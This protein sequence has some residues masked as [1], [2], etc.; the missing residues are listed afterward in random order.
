ML[1]KERLIR[2]RTESRGRKEYTSDLV[3]GNVFPHG[4][5]SNMNSHLVLKHS[6][7]HPN[8]LLQISCSRVQ[9]YADQK[10]IKLE[11]TPQDDQKIKWTYRWRS[12]WLMGRNFSWAPVK[13][14]RSRVWIQHLHFW[15][16][17]TELASYHTIY[18][19]P[20]VSENLIEPHLNSA[21][22]KRPASLTCFS[23][24]LGLFLHR[25]P[26][27]FTRHVDGNCLCGSTRRSTGC[28]I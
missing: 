27:T 20:N 28:P 12:A 19:L 5:I 16:N 7:M 23:D 11:Y 24:A 13:R 21:N 3:R 4:R 10:Q 17:S 8:E 14:H 9:L 26:H 25:I 18:E 1:W 22:S 2:D 15:A 6:K